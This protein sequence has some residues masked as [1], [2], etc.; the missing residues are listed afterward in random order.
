MYFW[1][2]L[3]AAFLVTSPMAFAKETLRI[4]T[5]EGYV[6]TEDLAAVNK[7][8]AEAG[9]DI[10]A[11]VITPYAS[12]PEQ[13]FESIRKKQCDISFLTLNYIKMQDEK[14][15]KLLQAINPQSPRM[16]NYKKLRKGLGSFPMGMGEQGPLYI[17]WAGGAYGIWANMKKLRKAD[18]P[19]SVKDLWNEK[20]K[21]ALSLSKGQ[22]QPNIALVMMAMLFLLRERSQPQPRTESLWRLGWRSIGSAAHELPRYPQ[23][24]L[25]LQIQ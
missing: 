24:L 15:L 17:P 10:E 3:V 6:T 8:L 19:K 1:V 18:L 7:L 25:S 2:I 23:L 11:R 4:F 21:G 16:P 12:G 5:W 20:W 13:M 22:V 14:T 9:Y